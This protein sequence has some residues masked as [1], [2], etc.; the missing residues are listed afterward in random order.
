MK[1][2]N[3]KIFEEV[4]SLLD[5]RTVSGAL[6]QLDNALLAFSVLG[7]FKEKLEQIRTTYGYM[8]DYALQGL[9]DPGLQ[10]SLA[11]TFDEI[12][13]LRDSMEREMMAADASTLYFNTLRFRRT[14][15]T[16]TIQ[17]LAEAYRSTVRRLSMAALAENAAQA[18]KE[19]GLKAEV[20]EMRL[21][22]TVWTHHPFTAADF[23]TLSSLLSDLSISVETKALLVSAITM[24]G[25]EWADERRLWLLLDTYTAPDT[26]TAV[27]ARAL[28]GILLLLS[29]HRDRPLSKTSADRLS[30]MRDLPQWNKEVMMAAMLF[31]RS[32]DTERLTRKFDEE[33]MPELMT[34]RPEIERL[35]R[36]KSRYYIRYL[37]TSDSQIS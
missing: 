21:F 34:M 24:G 20:L 19:L 6:D 37:L 27:A 36:L 8:R 14:A 13:A 32:R 9:P 23:E 3:N 17:A 2:T 35:T 10:Q 26:D 30:L 15:A 7:R 11:K 16:E 25:L 5:L 33:L 22:N 12:Y 31:V 1:T 29:G 28:V 18:Q 4:D